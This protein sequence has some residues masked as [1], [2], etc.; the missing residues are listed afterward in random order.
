M[1]T[2]VVKETNPFYHLF[3]NYIFGM[4]WRHLC[5]IHLITYIYKYIFIS[6]KHVWVKLLVGKIW[7]WCWGYHSAFGDFQHLQH[8]LMHFRATKYLQI[9]CVLTTSIFHELFMKS[10]DNLCS[11]SYLYTSITYIH[12]SIEWH[13]NTLK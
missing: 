12:V 10:L 9:V 2:G 6:I 5:W 13:S 1:G 4:L 7:M 3:T 8:V 11:L